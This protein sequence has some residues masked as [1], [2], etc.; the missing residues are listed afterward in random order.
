MLKFIFMYLL[1]GNNIGFRLL[2][3]WKLYNDCFVDM[4]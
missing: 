3:G 4:L 2:L 1:I